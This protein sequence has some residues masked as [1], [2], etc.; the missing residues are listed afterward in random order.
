[1]TLDQTSALLDDDFLICVF[2]SELIDLPTRPANRDRIYSN[3]R[4]QPEMHAGVACTFEA[5]I[6][7]YLAILF[8]TAGPYFDLGAKSIA[9]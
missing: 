9:V 5:A 7:S 3:G 2:R 1:M 4:T 8:E 6:G